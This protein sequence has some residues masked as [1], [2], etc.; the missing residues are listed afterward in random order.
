MTAGRLPRRLIVGAT[1]AALL[2]GAVG[3]VP[4]L[5]SASASACPAWTDPA[6]DSGVSTPAGTDPTGQSADDDL[7]LVAST[8][9]VAADGAL[10]VAVKVV[11]LDPA[12][13]LN[14]PG[15]EFVVSFTAGT[16]ASKVTLRRDAVEGTSGASVNGGT[17]VDGKVVFDDKTSTVTGTFTAAEVKSSFGKPLAGIKLSGFDALAY[18]YTE[19]P[20]GPGLG[21]PLTDEAP[22]PA[23]LSYTDAGGCGDTG[24]T[25]AATGSPSPTP[26]PTPTT[27]PGGL[28]DQPRKNC[29]QFKDATGDAAPDP[30]GADQED[31][32]DITQ[33]N[34]KSPAGQ[35]QVFVGLVDPSA[36]LFPLFSGPVYNVALTVGGKAVTLSAPGDGPATATVGG[37]ANTDIKATAKVDAKAKNVVFTV[38]LDGLAKA[39]GAPI[40]A[41]TAITGTTATTQADSDLGPL[42]ADSASGT[43]AAEK[44]YAYGD[45]TCFKPPPGVFSIDADRSAQYS[46]V[47]E[48]FA[49]LKDGDDSPVQGVLVSARLGSKV[50]SARTDD[51]GI[52]DLRLPVTV[53]AGATTITTTFAGND[54]V[55]PARATTPFKV[56]AEKTVL[57][58]AA[59]KGGVKA[60]V[61]DDDRH[62]VVGRVVVFT[63]AGKKKLVR[64][65]AKGLAVL[66][67]VARGTAVK[68]SFPAVPGYY[69]GTPTYTVKAL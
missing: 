55:G 52:A 10:Q 51:D 18:G 35:L 53:K 17:A 63:F 49:T 45:N 50:V 31:A 66:T 5:G 65:N 19:S 41:G 9:S 68:V 56:L 69:L 16:V 26:T 58:V 32:L 12:G 46:D 42:D 54:S 47:T 13:P 14:T 7:D 61:L 62:P 37:T 25:P 4:L 59:I 44:T 38:P 24:G 48:L 8:V 21:F 11:K 28:F 22:A 36:G 34:L 33:V 27:T 3:F 23:A 2:A 57:K 64:T 43:T 30:A 40:A 29:V 20:A 15:D 60:T 67:G 39:V 1:S 6:G